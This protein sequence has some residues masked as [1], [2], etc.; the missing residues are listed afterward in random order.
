MKKSYYNILEIK[1]DLNQICDF[2]NNS[3]FESNSP[4]LI[5]ERLVPHD[6]DILNDFVNKQTIRLFNELESWQLEN[7]GC[8]SLYDFKIKTETSNYLNFEFTTDNGPIINWL[9]K[10]APLYPNLLIRYKYES[11]NN[12]M[13]IGRGI[14]EHQFKQRSLNFEFLF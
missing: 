11:D 5:L 12:G 6:S 8:N 4:L 3:L 10:V 9:E 13:L 7:W 2:K 14:L 1:G